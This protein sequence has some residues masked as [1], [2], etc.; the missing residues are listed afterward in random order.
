[1]GESTTRSQSPY[2]PE[3]H[4]ME[5]VEMPTSSPVRDESA[6]GEGVGVGAWA[7][8]DDGKGMDLDSVTDMA[9]AGDGARSGVGGLD[10]GQP[11]SLQD[12]CAG[13]GQSEVDGASAR[14]CADH[15]ETMAIT[16]DTVEPGAPVSLQD[17][18]AVVG[19][20]SGGPGSRQGP[21]QSV[22]NKRRRQDLRRKERR[23]AQK[24]HSTPRGAP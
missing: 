17:V 20:S 16:G 10:S 24:A 3:L 11:V 15:D 8:P 7:P 9:G 21:A 2:D 4:T 12:V 13:V 23:S 14:R 18:A 1:M 5:E 22:L 6:L 19:T